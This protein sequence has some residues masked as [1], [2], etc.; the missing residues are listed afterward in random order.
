M[1]A[2]KQDTAKTRTLRSQRLGTA[3][4]AAEPSA[5]AASCRLV[6]LDAY[7]GFIMMMLAAGGFGIAQFMRMDM[8]SPVWTQIAGG[9]LPFGWS[10]ERFR[11]LGAFH[12]GHPAW[13]SIV[14]N[15]GVAF[16][17]LIQPA[18]LLRVGV[19]LPFSAARRKAE[20]QGLLRLICHVLVRSIVLVA[21]GVFLASRGKSGTH[22][23]FPNVLCQIGLGYTFVCLF[24]NRRYVVQF[25]VILAVLAGSWALFWLNPPSEGYAVAETSELLQVSGE[26]EIL[27]D[28][29]APW[30]KNANIAARVDNWLLPQLRDPDFRAS[31]AG[32]VPAYPDRLDWEP[33]I[34]VTRS[35][36]HDW[37]FT[38]REPYV[39]NSGGYTTLNFLPSIATMLLGAVCGRILCGGVH[40]SLRKLGLLLVLAGVCFSLGIACHLTIC[41]V[42]K[43]IWTPSWVLFSG[44]YVIGMLAL[45]YMLFDVLPLGFAA[46]PLVVVGTNSL[47]TY[48]MGQT[49]T[50]WVKRE[51][52]STHLA[53]AITSIFGPK[54]MSADWFQVITLP[55]AAF[56]VYW[57]FLL[58]LYRQKIFLR[59]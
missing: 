44:G 29:F 34:P 13:G 43:R 33:V 18:F 37:F 5:E 24:A 39:I 8:D 50:G 25:A 41:P 31:E 10:A 2:A 27:K 7:R 46:F 49:I 40:S 28:K 15:Y 22:W 52:V 1:N 51:I 59:I 12:F 26:E 48:M 14:Q 21:L 42:V 58:W 30:T 4:R 54:A 45:F 9:Q 3:P 35:W 23:V 17:D 6:S 38:D 47:L 55:T 11:E 32:A 20:G 36:Y 57:L 16:W 19:S 56:A 53:G